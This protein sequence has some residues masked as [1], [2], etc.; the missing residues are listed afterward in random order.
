MPMAPLTPSS[1]RLWVLLGA[2][3]GGVIA[4]AC[5]GADEAADGFCGA[6]DAAPGCGGELEICRERSMAETIEHPRCND[7]QAALEACLADLELACEGGADFDVF[8]NG[9]GVE[10]PA[11]AAYIGS[12]KLHVRDAACLERAKAWENCQLCSAAV[13]FGSDLGGVGDPCSSTNECA[14]GLECMGGGCTRACESDLDC[15]PKHGVLECVTA[16]DR[17]GVCD[18]GMCA[19]YCRGNAYEIDPCPP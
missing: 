2:L 18:A 6:L 8:A 10:D 1:Y 13:G 19:T 5:D 4:G 3:A 14:D 17:V 12:Y 16:N 11:F 7:Q 9:D 15:L